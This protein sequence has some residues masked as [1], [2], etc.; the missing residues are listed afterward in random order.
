[1]NRHTENFLPTDFYY[2]WFVIQIGADGANSQ[3]RKTIGCQ[4]LS[5]SYDQMA[6]VGTVEVEDVSKF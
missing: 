2:L 6:I 4:Y 5:W 1:M 3:V